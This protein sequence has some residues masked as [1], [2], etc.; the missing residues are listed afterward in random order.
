[1]NE[2]HN[3][4]GAAH[5]NID[6]NRVFGLIPA[7][8]GSKSIPLK[9]MALLGGKPL[10]SYVIKAAKICQD[11]EFISCSTDHDTIARYCADQGVMVIPRPADIS[12]DDAPVVDVL[13]HVLQTLHDQNGYVPGIL[14]LLQPTSPFVLSNHIS[15]LVALMRNSPKADSAQNI[16]P[17]VHNWHAFNQRTFHEG[18]V[19]FKFL[20]ERRKAYNKQRKPKLYQFG[21]LLVCRSRSILEGKDPFGDISVGLEINRPYEFDV[22]GPD[23]LEYAEYLL[24]YN[25]VELIN[26]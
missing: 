15:E 18:H 11:I 4:S 20:E 26:S 25:K 3:Q 16:V 6:E 12:G 8:G 1:M 5:F 24:K 7:R 10:I 14:V 17:V 23:D 2:K 21:N 9:N 22:D 19:Q 13:V